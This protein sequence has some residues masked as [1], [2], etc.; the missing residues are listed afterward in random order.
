MGGPDVM[1]SFGTTFRLTS[2]GESHG[3]AVGGVI[4]G[5]VAG[6]PVDEAFIQHELDRRKPGRNTCVTSRNEADTIHILSGVFDGYTLGTPIGFYVE[7]TNQR[8]TRH[9][10]P[11]TPTTHIII[12]IRGT[13]IIEA[14]AGPLQEKPFQESWPE[15]LRNSHLRSLHP[16]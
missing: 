5:M 16:D 1:N 14:E 10:G 8:S 12:S 11:L 6:I 2:F 7:N 13:G 15:R 3:K 4:D 9:S